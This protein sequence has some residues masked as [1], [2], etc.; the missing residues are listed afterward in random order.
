MG[1]L[2]AAAAWKAGS[3][4]KDGAWAAALLGAVVFGLGG[5]EWAVLLLAFFFSSSGLSR[6]FALRKR[7]LSEKFSKGSRRDAAQVLANGG[8]AGL[9]VLAHLAQPEALWP[10]AG[11]AGALA[12]VN[13]DTWATELGVLSRACPVLL[14]N[15][16]CVERGT[17]GGVTLWG[18][19][20]ALGGAALLGLLAGAL[21]PAGGGWLLGGAVTLGG[22]CGSL[23]D[24]LLGATF[25]AVYFCPACEKET[26]H[27]PLHT[28]GAQTRLRRGLPWLNNDLVNL[29]ASLAGAG[30]ALLLWSI[31]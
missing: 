27:H 18:T 4:R 19:L 16:R 8:L 3:L 22:V 9:F 29:A 2:V 15:G 26:E 21:F 20:A 30:A 14:T 6:L 1:I 25:Q 13:A 24:S 23:L 31:I 5:W 7:S 12:A 28:C 11:F 10:W 17:S